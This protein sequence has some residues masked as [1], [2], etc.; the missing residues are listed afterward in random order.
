MKFPQITLQ[1]PRMYGKREA[2]TKWSP[3]SY[4]HKGYQIEIE[5][6][7]AACAYVWYAFSDEGY[8]VASGMG[9]E[10]YD[11]HNEMSDAVGHLTY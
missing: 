8:L 2:A 5:W 11:A 9:E 6:D 4:E 10:I 1:W 3:I 7:Q